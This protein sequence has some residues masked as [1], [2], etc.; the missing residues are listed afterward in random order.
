[1]AIKK[2]PRYELQK[3]EFVM[4]GGLIVIFIPS[5]NFDFVNDMFVKNLKNTPRRVLV[6][7][8]F[9]NQLF[10]NCGV[11][12]GQGGKDFAIHFNTSLFEPIDKAAVG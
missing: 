3:D 7:F 12:F 6:L 11:I 2:S 5:K 9:F 4:V 1:M 8:N 10:E